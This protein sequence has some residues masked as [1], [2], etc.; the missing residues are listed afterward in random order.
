MS[1]YKV[2]A[3]NVVKDYGE[4]V[5]VNGIDFAVEEG[6]FFSLL[7]PSGCGKTTT[8][9]CI[10]GLEQ[11]TDGTIEIDGYDMT[12]VPPYERN[13]GL[14]FQSYA[15]F[16]HKTV[17]ENVGFGLKMEGVPEEERQERVGD[18]LE[19]LDLPGYEDRHPSELSGGQQQRVALA[20]ALVIEPS[21]L[22]LDEPLSNLDLK[23]RKQMRFELQRIQSEL[24]ITTVYVTH[25]QEEALSMSDQ[26]LVMNEGEIEQVGSPVEI[27]NEPANEFV[28]DFIG[29]T[30]LIGGRIDAVSD[31]TYD[32]W[33]DGVDHEA[34][35]VVVTDATVTDLS[36]GDHVSV[37]LRPEDLTVRHDPGEAANALEGTISAQTFLG[38]DTRL[39][40]TL[41]GDTD[42]ELL[43]E[44]TGK[45]GQ[46]QFDTSDEVV[47]EWEPADCLL[48]PSKS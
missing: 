35:I 13:T 8:L 16:P 26:I 7:G 6:D 38:K 12:D 23:L 48:I 30:N 19:L 44:T 28:A 3:D 37:N 4:V 40:V 33:L 18:M 32:I 41:P 36:P 21:V 2:R 22:L 17:G 31:G 46:Q 1:E 14:V 47:L 10:A 24:D 5:A 39:L 29:E 9:R 45:R 15:L 27:Y 25:D 11:L 43:V 34:P 20:R 42:E